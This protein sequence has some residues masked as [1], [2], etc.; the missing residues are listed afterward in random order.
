MKIENQA[1]FIDQLQI[2]FSKWVLQGEF[3]NDADFG[4]VKDFVNWLIQ[5]VANQ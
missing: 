5:E 3:T 4:N 1:E 2:I